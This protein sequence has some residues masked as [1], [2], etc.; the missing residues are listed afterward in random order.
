VV[1]TEIGVMSLVDGKVTTTTDGTEDGRLIDEIITTF[2][3]FGTVMIFELGKVDGRT[4]VGTKIGLTG[5]V[6][7]IQIGVFGI[8]AT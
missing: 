2:G 7:E 4:S 3:W 5:K 1:G 6:V 8:V